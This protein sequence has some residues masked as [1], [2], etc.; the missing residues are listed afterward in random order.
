M[1]AENI[2]R[3]DVGL[4]LLLALPASA[5]GQGLT[6]WHSDTVKKAKVKAESVTVVA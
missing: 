1:R 3:R 4:I 6:E 5:A 2:V